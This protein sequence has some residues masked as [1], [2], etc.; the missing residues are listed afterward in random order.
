[1][2]RRVIRTANDKIQN[3]SIVYATNRS[4][5]FLCRYVQSIK[6]G[7]ACKRGQVVIWGVQKGSGCYL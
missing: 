3:T 4:S 2:I 7:W 1:M 6:V 5:Y